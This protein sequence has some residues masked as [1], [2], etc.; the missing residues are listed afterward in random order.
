MKEVKIYVETSLC[1]PCSPREGWYA[2]KVEVETSKGP[3][4]V[5]E[6]GMEEETTWNRSTLMAVVQGLK[7]LNPGYKVI[8]VT[9]STFFKN[10][11]ERGNPESWKRSEWKKASGEEVKYKELWQEYL[12]L[13]AGHEIEVRFRK[14][15]EYREEL[16][17]RIDKKR[18]SKSRESP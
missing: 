2:V 18:Q 14:H 3:A 1:G 11:V 8:I 17:K 15:F 12:E 10:T 4:F 16:Q 13:A 6:V 7:K 5:G 9:Y